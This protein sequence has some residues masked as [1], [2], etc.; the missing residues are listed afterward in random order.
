MVVDQFNIERIRLLK[1][2]NNTPVGA[3][4]NRP[5]TLQ[6]AFKG[7]QTITGKVNRLRRIGFIQAGKN[8]LNRIQKV[9]P[10][11]AP[12][13]PFVKPF[14]ASMLEAPNHEDTP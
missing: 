6:V 12:V 2:E 4:G 3:Y 14:Q 13:A 7:V 9:G 10:Y 8:I 5:N 11:P 1:A